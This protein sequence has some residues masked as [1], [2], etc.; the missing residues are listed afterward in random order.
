[1][2]SSSQVSIQKAELQF[3]HSKKGSNGSTGLSDDDYGSILR[4]LSSY[5]TKS[6]SLNESGYPSDKITPYSIDFSR[7]SKRD[8]GVAKSIIRY[9]L[10]YSAG[11]AL[12]LLHLTY[13]S[14]YIYSIS[15]Q[16]DVK[17]KK[18]RNHKAFYSIH[19]SA[20]YLN[21]KQII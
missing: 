9:N 20:N 19:L 12:D 14:L 8:L 10:N 18:I 2:R 6:L 3:H 15:G 21:Y 17:I 4:R 16:E 5:S 13:N 11:S 1:M 7:I